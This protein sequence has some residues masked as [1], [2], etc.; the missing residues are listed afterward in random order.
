M[1]FLEGMKDD[2]VEGAAEVSA[3]ETAADEVGDVGEAPAEEPVDPD[4]R[5]AESVDAPAAPRA[6]DQ[7]PVEPTSDRTA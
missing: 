3:T 1:G 6:V 7:D 4:D 2:R 5:V